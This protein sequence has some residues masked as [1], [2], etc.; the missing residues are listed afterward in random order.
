M[1]LKLF[2]ML[3]KKKEYFNTKQTEKDNHLQVAVVM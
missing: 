3:H 1:L 2:F